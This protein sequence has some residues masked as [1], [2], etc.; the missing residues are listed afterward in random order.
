MRLQQNP[1]YN[2]YSSLN[3]TRLQALRRSNSLEPAPRSKSPSIAVQT[4]PPKPAPKTILKTNTS[5]S[6]S[7]QKKVQIVEPVPPE[8]ETPPDP[9][10]PLPLPPVETVETAEPVVE[11]NQIP[12]RLN[13]VPK[14]GERGLQRKWTMEQRRQQYLNKLSRKSLKRAEAEVSEVH[15]VLEESNYDEKKILDE[16]KRLKGKLKLVDCAKLFLI[17]EQDDNN[18]NGNSP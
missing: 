12:I 17:E 6:T 2:K 8:V 13:V 16:E 15:K 14:K 18:I 5:T 9:I 10:P 11:P 4:S 7:P 1:L 3:L